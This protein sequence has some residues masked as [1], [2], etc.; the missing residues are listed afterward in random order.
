MT[1]LSLDACNEYYNDKI[2]QSMFCAGKEEGGVDACQV[3]SLDS[4]LDLELD[5]TQQILKPWVGN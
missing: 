2:R 4:E 1:I 3:D 5:S